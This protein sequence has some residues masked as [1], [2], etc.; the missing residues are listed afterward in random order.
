MQINEMK[1]QTEL[2]QRP[3]LVAHK[4]SEE[5]DYLSILN[6]GNSTAINTHSHV[7]ERDIKIEKVK[8]PEKFPGS[9]SIIPKDKEI[10]IDVLFHDQE[11]VYIEYENVS[12]KR[13]FSLV[14]VFENTCCVIKH[15][16]R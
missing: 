5:G 14:K 16:P 2:Q 1:Q 3:F 13:Y 7:K 12:G 11:S 4:S 15:G 6:I 8:F 10:T 9:L